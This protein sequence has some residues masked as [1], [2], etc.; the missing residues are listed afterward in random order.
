VV[1][2]LGK[3]IMRNINILVEADL[4]L[5]AFL[6]IGNFTQNLA[7]FAMAVLLYALSTLLFVNYFDRKDVLYFSSI[8]DNLF[9]SSVILLSFMVNCLF[10]QL[11]SLA[12]FTFADLS[13][14]AVLFVW[15]MKYG[16]LLVPHSGFRLFL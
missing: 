3:R 8:K 16:F 2:G 6:L 12:L 14:S 11:G 1:G 13:L 15:Y 10:V 9:L 7:G 5:S 4:A